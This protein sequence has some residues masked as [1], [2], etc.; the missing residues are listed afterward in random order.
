MNPKNLAIWT[1][2]ALHECMTKFAYE[3]Y[4]NFSHPGLGQSPR[5]A[6]SLAQARSGT[7]EHRYI[8]YNEE[9]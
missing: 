7:R 3:V 5:N 9:A 1:L 8:P 6:F 2:G 4:D